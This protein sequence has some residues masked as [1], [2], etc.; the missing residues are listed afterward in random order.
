MRENLFILPSSA[1]SCICSH[2]GGSLE[3]ED[4]LTRE[5]SSQAKSSETKDSY[6][7]ARFSPLVLKK[8][9]VCGY[10]IEDECFH[11]TIVDDLRE[12]LRKFT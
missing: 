5:Y 3:D 7:E 6:L 8:L 9:L 4:T 10:T 11:R 2:L 1:I 12:M